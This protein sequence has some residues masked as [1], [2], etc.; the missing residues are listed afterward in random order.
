MKTTL[1]L[2]VAFCTAAFAG[3]LKPLPVVQQTD[4][5]AAPVSPPAHLD[6]M[7]LAML[8]DAEISRQARTNT[9][10]CGPWIDYS[11]L[12]TSVTLRVTPVFIHVGGTCWCELIQDSG[13]KDYAADH[14][15]MEVTHEPV[16][17]K[18]NGK[19]I[20]RFKPASK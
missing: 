8:I 13:A 1:I 10:F 4:Y 2:I 16:V 11:F 14:L 19:W 7:R 12:T 15:R 9:G 6:T 20:I 18:A 3:D 17:T 5:A